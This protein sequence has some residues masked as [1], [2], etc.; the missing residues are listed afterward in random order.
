MV[1]ASAARKAGEFRVFFNR[2]GYA[3]MDWLAR[4]SLYGKVKNLKLKGY[5][6][7]EHPQSFSSSTPRKYFWSPFMFELL[8]EAHRQR[9]AGKPDFFDAPNIPEIR[10]FLSLL[11]LKRGINQLHKKHKT[12]TGLKN[13]L[14]ALAIGHFRR[15]ILSAAFYQMRPLI[16]T[17][18]KEP[19]LI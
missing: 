17:K 19:N 15:E 18:L 7:R 3:D 6:Y 5:Y 10:G 16:K 2:Q 9:I 12:F 13:I 8:I 1:K 11:L 14:H 4:C